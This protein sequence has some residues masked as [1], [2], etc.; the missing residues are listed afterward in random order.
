MPMRSFGL[1]DPEFYEAVRRPRD[2][3][4]WGPGLP[5]EPAFPREPDYVSVMADSEAEA[6][7]AIRGWLGHVGAGRIGQSA[8]R[9][10]AGA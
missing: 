2:P 5:Q 8:E 1:N 7:D 4:R 10:D 9:S 3:H 6:E